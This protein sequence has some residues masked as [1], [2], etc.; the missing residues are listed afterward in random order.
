MPTYQICVTN[1]EFISTDDHEC[2]DKQAAHRQAIKAALDIAADQVA[3]G[4]PFFGAEVTL[5]EGNKMLGR[6][7]VA[8]GAS[9]LKD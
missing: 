2:A 8:V 6:Y 3:S 5:E 4:K 9:P 1:E 7:V